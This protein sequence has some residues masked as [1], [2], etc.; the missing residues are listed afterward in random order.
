[1]STHVPTQF[2]FDCFLSYSH[3][4]QQRAIAQSLQR[5]LHRFARSFWRMRAVRV[6]R[7]ETNLS[8]N[9]ALFDTIIRAL[10]ASNYLL[11]LA[12]P[13]AAKSRWVSQELVHWL[14][15][16]RTENLI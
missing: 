11:V 6:F 3:S 5:G 10:D 15:N 14:K 13:A 9:P 2:S 7:D 1:M 16:R 8:A 12:S 4:D